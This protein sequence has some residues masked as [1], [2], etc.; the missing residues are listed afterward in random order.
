MCQPADH[1][2]ALVLAMS[3]VAKAEAS[4]TIQLAM[5]KLMAMFPATHKI[6]AATHSVMV[7]VRSVAVMVEYVI[8][9]LMGLGITLAKATL[10]TATAAPCP[11]IIIHTDAAASPTT[12]VAHA[13]RRSTP[14]SQ[15][16]SRRPKQAKGPNANP[17]DVSQSSS[18]MDCSEM[19]SPQGFPKGLWVL[20]SSFNPSPPP[21]DAKST[22]PLINCFCCSH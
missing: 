20:R 17:S 2:M 22:L 18:G 19:L 7:R 5:V 6:M 3:A 15:K 12:N 4:G 1:I 16:T 13:S 14:C 10:A 9:A 8:L 21:V 11:V